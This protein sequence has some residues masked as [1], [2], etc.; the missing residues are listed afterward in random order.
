VFKIPIVIAIL[1][2]IFFLIFGKFLFNLLGIVFICFLFIILIFLISR[3][4]KEKEIKFSKDDIDK[5]I[6]IS[7]K[8]I[9]KIK[10]YIKE[11]SI[12][13]NKATVNGNGLGDYEE[14]VKKYYSLVDK[15]VKR[16]F[17][18][19]YI[20]YSNSYTKSIGEYNKNDWNYN[21]FSIKYNL[22]KY[23]RSYKI[24]DSIFITLHKYNTLNMKDVLNIVEEFLPK[25]HIKIDTTKEIYEEHTENTSYKIKYT[26]SYKSNLIKNNKGVIK[27]VIF[28]I[29][30]PLIHNK[31]DSVEYKEQFISAKIF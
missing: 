21:I 23:K 9:Y 1:L 14:N 5:Y 31:E 15:R 26:I 10:N 20:I 8:H 4:I 30:A 18:Y 28:K 13:V 2:I 22:R 24:V 7:M 6:N 25:D 11:K 3:F 16:E 12:K 17:G 19:D 29:K 27:V